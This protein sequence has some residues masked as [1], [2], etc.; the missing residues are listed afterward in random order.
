MWRVLFFPL[1][2]SLIACTETRHGKVTRDGALTHLAPIE[3]IYP[4]L[5]P[6]QQFRVSNRLAASLYKGVKVNDFYASTPTLQPKASAL[7]PATLR[8][9]LSAK[10]GAYSQKAEQAKTRFL[11]ESDGSE[12]WSPLEEPLVYMYQLGISRDYFDLWMA[13]QLVNNILFSPALELESV[14]LVDVKS[15]YV[16]LV[17]AIKNDQPISEIVYQHM[18]S[19][20]NWRR[21]RSPEDNAREMM[22]IFLMRYRDDEVPKA[23]KACQNWYIKALQKNAEVSYELVKT[24]DMNTESQQLLD[25]SNIVS[26]EDFYRALVEN[27]T[28]LP[29]VVTRIVNEFFAYAESDLKKTIVEE[30]LSQHPKTFRDIFSLIIFSRAYLLDVPRVK[31]AEEIIFN[32]A[33]VVDWEPHW[34][35]FDFFVRGDSEAGMDRRNLSQISQQTMTYKLGRDTKIAVDTLSIAYLASM[36]RYTMFR[37]NSNEISN[38]LSRWNVSFVNNTFVSTLTPQDFI[39]Y[40]FLSL[41][42]RQATDNEQAALQN[43]MNTEG[44]QNLN[45]SRAT[46]IFDYITN[47]PEFYYQASEQVQ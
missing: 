8:S 1:L 21:F 3:K 25:V 39:N 44:A 4:S 27:E 35:F 42:S 40:V 2:I 45:I 6:D 14:S 41:L 43:I 5:S 10:D 7:T 31:T 22:E 18:I 9:Q 47:L 15:I 29:T 38:G 33:T 19:E 24:L 20:E 12:R 16:R 46:I 30:I 36:V 13:Y 32:T 11:T 34:R 37:N 23:A 17:E 26:C 28:L